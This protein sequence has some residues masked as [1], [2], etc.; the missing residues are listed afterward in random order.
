METKANSKNTLLQDPPP[1]RRFAPEDAPAGGPASQRPGAVAGETV[2]SGDTV[3]EGKIMAQSELRIDGTFKGE[4]VS[5]NRVIVGTAG[6]LEG[7][8]EAKAMILSGRVVG[9]LKVSERLELQSTG[10]LF[11]DLETQPGALLIEK[12]ARLE[13]RCSMGLKKDKST[14]GPSPQPGPGGAPSPQP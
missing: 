3:I 8:V 13:G 6:K 12:G 1:A 14:P 7:T 2:I 4:I 9:N 11:G 10:E 5:A